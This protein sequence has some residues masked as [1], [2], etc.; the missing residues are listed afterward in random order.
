M[1]QKLGRTKK[2]IKI[3]KISDKY[4][5]ITVG[6]KISLFGNETKISLEMTPKQREIQVRRLKA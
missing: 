5:I 2:V 3:G 1:A 4:D 6:K